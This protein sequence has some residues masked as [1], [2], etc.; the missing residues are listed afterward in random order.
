MSWF[1]I[2]HH[3]YSSNYYSPPEAYCDYE[4]KMD[5]EVMSCDDCPY[6]YSEEDYEA[7]RA[8]YL[9]DTYRDFL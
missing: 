2:H 6:C 4:D 1:C 5:I 8:D 9:Y 3:A 7:D